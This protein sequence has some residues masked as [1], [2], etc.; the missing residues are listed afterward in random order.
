VTA[1]RRSRDH[2]AATA[3]RE[4]NLLVPLKAQPQRR[5]ARLKAEHPVYVEVLTER[6][7][8]EFWRTRSIG[9]GGCSFRSSEGLGYLSLTKVAIA[10]RGRVVTADGR[11]VYAV[12]DREGYEV[13]V[14][15][16]RV[17]QEDRQHIRALVAGVAGA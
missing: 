7:P 4:Y 3:G 2:G 10:L 16:L 15:F 17:S 12:R 6:K 13:G 11:V 8:G 1:V 14:E 5:F 9:E